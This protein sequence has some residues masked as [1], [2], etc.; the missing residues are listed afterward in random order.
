IVGNTAAEEVIARMVERFRQV[1]D[2]NF[3]DVTMTSNPSI[4]DLVTTA[5]IIETE[6]KLKQERPVIASVIYNRLKKEMPLGVDSTIVYAAKLAGK[7]RN[8]GIVYQSDVDRQSPYNT[9]IVKGLP[10]GPVCSPGLAS[11]KAALHPAK[12]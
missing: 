6:A 4:H 11:L 8:D 10:P 9:R 5:S 3:K 1:R 12:T 7:W 2:S